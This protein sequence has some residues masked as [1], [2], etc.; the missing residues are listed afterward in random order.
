MI[1]W[2]VS[3]TAAASLSKLLSPQFGESIL[4]F[5]RC[6]FGL[7]FVMPLVLKTLPLSVQ[8]TNRPLMIL[9]VVLA[10]F[11]MMGS[12]FAYR[13]IPLAVGCAIS[14]TGPLVTTCLAVLILK[15]KVSWKHWLCVG[16]GYFGVF[17]IAQPESFVFTTP[18]YVFFGVVIMVSLMIICTRILSKTETSAS[19]LF[20]S[21]LGGMLISGLFLLKGFPWPSNRD[22]FIMLG[23]SFCGVLS[24]LSYMQALKQSPA[25]LVSSFEYTRLVF[26]IPVGVYFFAE[27]PEINTYIGA[28]VIMLAT[29][30]L[31][32]LDNQT[33]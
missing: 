1:G 29:F 18:V 14:F 9:R 32:R 21:N 13:H 7:L 17:I 22:I 24:Q 3:F 12:Y 8:V 2:S 25:S 4:V 31:S 5:L 20:Y 28:A 15:E 6:F 23:V 16:L 10:C 11:A 27:I 26:A 33:S 19:M 30:W